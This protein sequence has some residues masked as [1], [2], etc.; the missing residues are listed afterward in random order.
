MLQDVPEP[1]EALKDEKTTQSTSSSA[2]FT[3][4]TIP[5]TAASPRPDGGLRAWLFLAGASIIEI[6]AWGQSR[7]RPSTKAI[8][9]S[10]QGFPYCYGVF[11]AYFF[12]HAP[13][14]G[15]EYVSVAGVLSNASAVIPNCYAL[16]YDD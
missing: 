13:F 7:L 1:T 5:G 9:N 4:P 15:V 12:T 6:V 11:R 3:T 16:A 8:A 2:D 10:V 14:A